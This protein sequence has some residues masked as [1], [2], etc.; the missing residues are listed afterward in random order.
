MLE[1]DPD[2]DGSGLGFVTSESLSKRLSIDSGSSSGSSSGSDRSDDGSINVSSEAAIASAARDFLG[3][4]VPGADKVGDDILR[5]GIRFVL[6]GEAVTDPVPDAKDNLF[7]N[8]L[9]SFFSALA[10]AASILATRS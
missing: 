6:S 9:C 2:S 4:I 3:V 7:A 5:F 10:V 8:S 1:L